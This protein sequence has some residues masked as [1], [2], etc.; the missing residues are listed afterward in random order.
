MSIREACFTILKSERRPMLSSELVE[1]LRK[2]GRPIE[3]D[4]SSVLSAAL[5]TGIAKE[6]FVAKKERNKNVWSL[7][8][9]GEG[10]DGKSL[11]LELEG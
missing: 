2:G 11:E 10:D 3:G 4:S 6:Q 9:W 8:E 5:S 7:A 1:A